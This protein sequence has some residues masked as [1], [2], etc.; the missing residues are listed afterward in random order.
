M[1]E[2][3]L[4]DLLINDPSV[5]PMVGGQPGSPPTPG[6]RVRPIMLPAGSSYPAIVYLVVATKPLTSMDGVNALQ[7]KRFQIDCYGKNAVQAKTLAKA[8]HFLLDGFRG[9]LSEGTVVSCCLPNQDVDTFDF[10]PQAFRVM[11]DFN[12]RFIEFPYPN[13]DFPL[14]QGPSQTV[15]LTARTYKGITAAQPFAVFAGDLLLCDTS[16]GDITLLF[17]PSADNSHQSVI[18]K[19]TSSDLNQVI[20]QPT[21]PDTINMFDSLAFGLDA[22]VIADGISNWW[23]IY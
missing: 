5:G 23:A 13:N 3:G 4:R 9:T 20:I 7:M 6:T 18:V 17:P 16:E 2:K 11:C 1:V 8:V 14:G 12:I 15:E 22:V 21:S 10:D 19:K